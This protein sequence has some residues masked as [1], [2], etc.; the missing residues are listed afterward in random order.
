VSD[1]ISHVK[2]D[3]FE[4]TVLQSDKPVLV[5]FWAEWCH[6]CHMVSPIVE[7]IAREN[8]GRLRVVKINI[9]E[10]P[11]VAYKYAIMSIPTLLLFSGGEIQAKVVGVRGK[12]AILR[13]IEPHLT[14]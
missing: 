3:E 9:D 14:A 12:D 1:V 13:E 10:E 11:D 8:P 4:Q 7:E 6:P 5:D 2:D